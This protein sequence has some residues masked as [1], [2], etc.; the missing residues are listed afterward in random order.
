MVEA[1]S[2][3]LI[4]LTGFLEKSQKAFLGAPCLSVDGEDQTFVFGVVRDL[5]QLRHTLGIVRGVVVIGEEGERVTT[6]QNLAKTCLFLKQLRVPVVHDSH[7]RTIDLCTG[8]ASIVSHIVTHDLNLL[9]LA[10]EDRRVV[11]LKDKNEI[12]VFTADSVASRLGVAPHSV[13]G[14]LALTSGPAPTVVTKREA[15][16]LLQRPGDLAGKISDP[17][18]LSSRRLRHRLKT[19]C[20]IILQR[21]REFSASTPVPSLHLDRNRLEVDIDNDG[22]RRLLDTYAFYSLK[23]LLPKPAGVPVLQAATGQSPPKYH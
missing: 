17:T 10:N 1:S 18:F 5:L 2:T 11:V 3:F 14:F 19:N 6:A 15:I 22:S 23:R 9:Q 4:D 12:E 20:T 7:K 13:P 21:V 8:A 16:G